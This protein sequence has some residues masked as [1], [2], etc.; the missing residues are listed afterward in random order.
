LSAPAARA[1]AQGFNL[2]ETDALT[3]QWIAC[4]DPMSAGQYPMKRVGNM[5]TIPQRAQYIR[6][7]A[8]EFTFP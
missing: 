2:V 1:V 6:T 5:A 8:A 4:G 7:G 3:G